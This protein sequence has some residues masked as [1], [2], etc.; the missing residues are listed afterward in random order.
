MILWKWE[1]RHDD[2]N[3]GIRHDDVNRGIQ[4]SNISIPNTL[5]ET[6]EK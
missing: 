6:V 3:R 1:I 5:L 4:A 2:V